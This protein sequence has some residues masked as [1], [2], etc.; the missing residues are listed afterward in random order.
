MIRFQEG[1]YAL[2][3]LQRI[4]LAGE[5]PFKALDLIGDKIMLQRT[6]RKLKEQKYITINGN[7]DLKTIR[8]TK[9]ALAVLEENYKDYYDYYMSITDNH[10]FRAGT[11]KKNNVGVRQTMR[12]HRLAEVQCILID[13]DVALLP[14][15]KPTLS[16][17]RN[18]KSIDKDDIVFYSSVEMKNSDK[19]QTYKTEFT[20]ILGT[21]YCPGGIYCLYNTNKGRIKWNNQG[22]QKA[23]VL[24][25]DLTQLNY[26]IPGDE[27]A[28]INNS[29]I[30]GKSVD[31]FLDI[32]SSNG[33]KHDANGFELLSFNNTYDNIYYI[34]LDQN[35]LKQMS[36]LIEDNWQER[37][38]Y[39][40]F[41]KELAESKP[42][43][44]SV[45]CDAFNKKEDEFILIF[46]DGNISRLKR[47]KEAIYD[48]NKKFS[49]VCFPWQQ[50]AVD[51]YMENMATSIVVEYEDVKSIFFNQ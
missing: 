9:K 34:T 10:H 12:R 5:F 21:L 27:Y 16:L 11:Y 32:L 25:E 24:I 41:P 2:I 28:D 22:E 31:L 7:A 46:I 3:I 47:F 45:D 30:F 42:L 36:F 38:R 4:A 26:N 20:R 17:R 50:E 48:S 51:T 43:F 40:I 33:G 14:S 49:V 1:S 19:E 23:K 18:E 35:G 6:I 15:E 8:L 13:L 39:S 37:L 44:S 29:V